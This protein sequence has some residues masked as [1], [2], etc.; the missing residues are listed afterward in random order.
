MSAYAPGTVAMVTWRNAEPGEGPGVRIR[1]AQ[2]E[3]DAPYA[4]RRDAWW[5]PNGYLTDDSVTDV[6]PLVVLDLNETQLRVVVRRLLSAAAEDDAADSHPG[7]GLTT[8]NAYR[9]AATQIETQ[10]GPPKPQ[11]PQGLGAVVEDVAGDYWVRTGER[12]RKCTGPG[13]GSFRPYYEIDA[14]RVLS[15]GVTPC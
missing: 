1:V 13:R 11:E 3:T 2:G 14:V 9:K 12:F 10:M 15:E 4:S 8:S 5:G 7:R 6:R